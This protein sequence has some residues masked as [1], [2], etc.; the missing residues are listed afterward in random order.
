MKNTES[1]VCRR[2]HYI[3][4]LRNKETNKKQFTEFIGYDDRGNFYMCEP[5]TVA[6]MKSG[7]FM[8]TNDGRDFI[9]FVEGESALSKYFC[10]TC[11]KKL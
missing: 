6:W 2:C 3:G 11:G 7:K 8:Y 10:P 5:C 1:I 4:S 9:E